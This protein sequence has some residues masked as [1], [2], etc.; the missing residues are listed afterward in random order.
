MRDQLIERAAQLPLEV[1][2][3]FFVGGANQQELAGRLIA[4]DLADLL[5]LALQ[6]RRRCDPLAQIVLEVQLQDAACAEQQQRA[7]QPGCADAAEQ[8]L[9]SGQPAFGEPH[10]RR[11]GAQRSVEQARHQAQRAEK[12][13]EQAG[14]GEDCHL[15]QRRE[16]REG[17]GQVADQIGRQRQAQ[18]WQHPSQGV[19]GAPG[20]QAPALG[21]IVQREVQGHADQACPQ[22]QRQHVDLA[23]QRDA[24]RRSAEHA[25]QYRQHR[26]QHPQ[27]AKQCQQQGDPGEQRDAADQAAFLPSL[28]LAMGGIQQA[29]GGQQL[30]ACGFDPAACGGDLGSDQQGLLLVEGAG[31][32]ARTQQRPVAI[33]V[34]DAQGAAVIDANACAL[35]WMVLDRLGQAEPILRQRHQRTAAEGVEQGLHPRLDESLRLFEQLLALGIAEQ[36]KTTSEQLFAYCCEVGLQLPL[37]AFVEAAAFQFGGQRGGQR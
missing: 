30:A 33:L 18:P 17:Q 11:P 29:A 20:L 8:T 35:R 9:A 14:G 1:Q 22:H 7:E 23:E 16:G 27:R 36:G 21:Q 26:R 6:I 24:G 10:C 32:A 34:L 25:D 19:G 37:H 4:D 12:G 2:Q 13:A 28:L 3:G 31:T 5:G 15:G